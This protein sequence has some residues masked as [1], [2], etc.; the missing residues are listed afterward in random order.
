MPA[1]PSAV[2]GRDDGERPAGA[3]PVGDVAADVPAA[4]GW[5]PLTAALA[6]A[7][8]WC[9]DEAAGAAAEA[10]WASWRRRHD[11]PEVADYWR[12]CETLARD[13]VAWLTDLAVFLRGWRADLADREG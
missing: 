7:V 6:G 1:V 8:W 9:Q 11:Q 2:G 12:A 4:D 10:Q 5:W 3:V 13:R